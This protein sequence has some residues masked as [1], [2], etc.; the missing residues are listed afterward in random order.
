[1]VYKPMRCL[2]AVAAMC[3]LGSC[4]SLVGHD[5]LSLE[6]R[7]YLGDELRMDGYYY[8]AYPTSQG[9]RYTAYLF[10]RNG[11]VRY[12]GN[13]PDLEILESEVPLYGDKRW[14]WGL[15]HVDGDRIAFELWYPPSKTYTEAYVRSGQILNDTT[16][17][18]TEAW[19][20]NDEDVREK[21]EVYHF[22]AFSPKPDSTS[23]YID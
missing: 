7:P 14:H 8:Y 23:R 10:Y 19:R 18:I 1:M 3:L 2:I 9:I 12:G 4:N 11:V 22:R 6:R 20:S 21:D 15:F 5:E 17:V 13:T 16:F